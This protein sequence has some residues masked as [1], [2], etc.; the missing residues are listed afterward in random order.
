MKMVNINQF[1]IKLQ[2]WW[3]LTYSYKDDY[4]E[5]NLSWSLMSNIIKL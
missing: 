1:Y 2:L 4:Q 5:N 3:K